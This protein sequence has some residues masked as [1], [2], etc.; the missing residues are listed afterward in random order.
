[1]KLESNNLIFAVL[2]LI[3]IVGII[4]IIIVN[5]SIEFVVSIN[6]PP[7]ISNE[8]KLFIFYPT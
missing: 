7:E 3:E 2:P 4:D 8:I 6:V 1:M 5:P